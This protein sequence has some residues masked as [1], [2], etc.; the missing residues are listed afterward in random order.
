M[1][2]MNTL[3]G[4]LFGLFIASNAYGQAEIKTTI[5]ND[6]ILLGNTCLLTIELDGQS[7]QQV[8]IDLP[9]TFTLVSGPNVSS[10]MT[11]INGDISQTSTYSY[12]IKPTEI[13]K[14]Y[15]PPLTIHTDSGIVETTPIEV[16]TYPN[17]DN[18]VQEVEQQSFNQDQFNF[19][20]SDLFDSPLFD[21]I[22]KSAEEENETDQKPKRPLKR[23]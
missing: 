8:D 6:S 10:S 22:P 4:I 1:K 15:I 9:H 16:H 19:D 3:L 14:E 12:Y 18:I 20:F 21:R 13:G 7:I 11:M 23:I 2:H 17:P 5:S